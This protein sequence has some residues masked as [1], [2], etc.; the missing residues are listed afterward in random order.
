MGSIV[1]R[2]PWG[3]AELI[4]CSDYGFDE[5]WSPGQRR[6]YFEVRKLMC[7]ARMS[8]RELSKSAEISK[9]SVSRLLAGQY[10]FGP[11][12][13]T[14]RQIYNFAMAAKDNDLELIPWAYLL[15]LRLD[16][17]GRSGGNASTPR[18][19]TAVACP[20]C[21]AAVPAEPAEPTALDADTRVVAVGV[22]VPVPVSGTGTSTP[23]L[24]GR[25]AEFCGR[26]RPTS[27]A[28]LWPAN[29]RLRAA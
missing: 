16:I 21:G 12:E 15:E 8:H 25:A 22:D 19:L 14:L 17:A 11:R 27:P 2:L 28:T 4:K 20:Q 7:C 23:T 6:F 13:S 18:P 9:Y 26:R 1:R 29:S 24:R 3:R 10:R 5:A